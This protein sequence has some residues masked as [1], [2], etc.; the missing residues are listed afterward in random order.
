[1]KN[2]LFSV[3]NQ[4]K[5]V[6]YLP[7]LSFTIIVLP[8]LTLPFNVKSA[9]LQQV[10]FC[11]IS[12][13]QYIYSV[14]LLTLSKAKLCIPII[15]GEFTVLGECVCLGGGGGEAG[16]SVHR[17]RNLVRRSWIR[18]WVRAPSLFCWISVSVMCPAETEVMVSP[19]CLCMAAPKFVRRQSWGKS[20][21]YP[22]F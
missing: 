12:A 5:Q 7:N 13:P 6:F 3:P 15:D 9:Y 10:K 2:E 16:S 20:V 8:R 21:R 19:L 22:S 18:S 14:N 4:L 11:D 1:M 17:T